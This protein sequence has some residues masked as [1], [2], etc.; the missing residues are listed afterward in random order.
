MKVFAILSFALILAVTGYFYFFIK[1]D[2]MHDS[3]S[4]CGRSRIYYIIAD[5][6]PGRTVFNA[7]NIQVLA[8]GNTSP[9]H[10]HLYNDPQGGTKMIPRWSLYPSGPPR[11]DGWF[12]SQ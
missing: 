7:F 5:R 11:D 2:E 4:L 12:Q 6:K 1:V 9:T 10:R 8:P 3:C